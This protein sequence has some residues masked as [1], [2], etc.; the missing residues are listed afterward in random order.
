MSYR[1]IVPGAT[2]TSTA[3][4]SSR[5]WPP[6]ASKMGVKL[7]EIPGGDAAAL[8]A[9]HRAGTTP[10]PTCPRGTGIRYIDPNFNLSVVT[11]AQWGNNSDTG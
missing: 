2:S 3:T 6:P 7:H 1:V 5:S 11:K 8:H 9:D 10:R 4:A